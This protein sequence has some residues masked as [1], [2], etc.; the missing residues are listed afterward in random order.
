MPEFITVAYQSYTLLNNCVSDHILDRD[1]SPDDLSQG[2]PSLDS[3]KVPASYSMIIGDLLL[4][5]S[6]ISRHS[7]ELQ[8]LNAEER[9]LLVGLID[10]LESSQ[11]LDS[12]KMAAIKL[13]YSIS[14]KE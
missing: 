6:R 11:E 2:E 3:E 4:E 9:S 8:F 13:V 12:E 7:L 10:K 5:I 1:F 14:S